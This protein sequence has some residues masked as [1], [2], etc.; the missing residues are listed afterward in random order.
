MGKISFE[1]QWVETKSLNSLPGYNS[2]KKGDLFTISTLYSRSDGFTVYKVIHEG[3][4]DHSGT[5][6]EIESCYFFQNDSKHWPYNF[7]EYIDRDSDTGKEKKFKF[8]RYMT[9]ETIKNG[10]TN[11]K[12]RLVAFGEAIKSGNK[13][14]YYVA[15]STQAKGSLHTSLATPIWLCDPV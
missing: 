10:K 2:P 4:R 8:F 9:I 3:I 15:L 12:P 1:G 5:R 14:P 6:E 11:K 13:Y 7:V